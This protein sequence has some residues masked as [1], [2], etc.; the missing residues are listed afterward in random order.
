[1]PE[2]LD[3]VL[4]VLLWYLAVESDA[5]YGRLIEPGLDKIES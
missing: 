2:S 5:G 3:N 4:S 1:M